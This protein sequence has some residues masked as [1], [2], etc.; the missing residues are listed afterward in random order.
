MIRQMNAALFI[1]FFSFLPLFGQENID[2]QNLP[3]KLENIRYRMDDFNPGMLPLAIDGTFKNYDGGMLEKV[4]EGAEKMFTFAGEF[5]LSPDLKGTDLSLMLGPMDY[6]ANIYLNGTRIMVHG[7][8]GREHYVSNSYESYNVFLP[9]SLMFYGKTNRIILQAYPVSETTPMSSFTITTDKMGEKKTFR[10]NLAGVYVIRGASVLAVF[11]FVFFMIYGLMDRFRDMNYFY[12]A[13]M[14]LSFVLAYLEITLSHDHAAE[15]LIKIFAKT[16]FTWIA[17]LAVYF[18]T[19]YTGIFRENRIRKF[20]PLIIA[21]IYTVLYLTRNSK[22]SIDAIYGPMTQFVLFPAILFNIVILLVSV[23]RQKKLDSIPLLIS[24]LTVVGT[25]GHDIAYIARHELPYAY[26]TSY[27][28]LALVMFIFFTL[29]IKQ[30]RT[31][32]K[33][34]KSARILDEKNR[35]QQLMIDNIRKVSEALVLSSREIES[36]VSSTSGKIE[37]SSD[38]NERITGEVFSRVSELKQVIV[39]MEERLK[40]SSEKIPESIRNQSSAVEDVSR[41]IESLNEHLSEVLQFAEDTRETADHLAGMASSSTKV[42][43]ESN[44]SIIEVSEYSNFISDVLNA[45]E[46]I[47][48]KTSLLSINAAIEAARAG[49]SGKGFSVVAGEI[50]S[51]SSASKEQLDSS[52]QKIED[53]KSSIEQS[54][55]LSNRVSGT[56]DSIIG[57]TKISTGKIV[58]MT[59][60]LNEQKKESAAIHNSVVSLLRDTQIIRDLSEES[61]KADTSVAKTMGEIRDLF[62]SITEILTNQ[63]DQYQ[64]LYQFMAHIQ[65]VVEENLSNVDILQSCIAEKD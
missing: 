42:I 59:E 44:K 8:A 12:F 61:R 39:E 4:S 56:L 37:H 51:L 2:R 27:G 38:E 20:A 23:F 26:L 16:G 14:C 17:I 52:F 57:S 50:R 34:Q 21:L 18:V 55:E 48:E 31:S 35:T 11:L 5:N 62:L 3:V 53:M 36:K 10:R 25:A 22:E 9:E 15:V 19:E 24:F 47:T 45:I 28:F 58:S 64:E 13:L 40:V 49:V 6:P 33:A 43:S 30:A 29:A 46:D 63:K 41:T 1:L 65:T 7:D 54:R 60:K 32:E